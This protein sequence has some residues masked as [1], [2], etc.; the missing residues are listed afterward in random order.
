MMRAIE[1]FVGIAKAMLANMPISIV[2][3]GAGWS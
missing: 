1:T 2:G 3:N